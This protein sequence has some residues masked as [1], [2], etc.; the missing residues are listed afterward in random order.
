MRREAERARVV[1]TARGALAVAAFAVLAVALMALSR[2]TFSL[3]LLVLV[4]I[5]LLLYVPRAMAT[6]RRRRARWSPLAGEQEHGVDE[7]GI[8]LRTGRL[9]LWSSWSGLVRWSRAD[10]V[11]RLHCLGMPEV[12][13]PK[14]ALVQ[15]GCLEAV[16]ELARTSSSKR[17]RS[18]ASSS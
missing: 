7:T 17:R 5:A 15:A 6:D 3:G 12:V 9:E 10:G 4:T 18:A 1:R 16:L 14:D 8:W 13:I 11:V 2:W